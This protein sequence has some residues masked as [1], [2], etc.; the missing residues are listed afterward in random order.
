MPGG[1]LESGRQRRDA[2]VRKREVQLCDA[3]PPP[4]FLKKGRRGAL[5]P[6][7]F[8]ASYHCS[9]CALHKDS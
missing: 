2:H 3:P 9:K 5:Y 1:L 4:S 8:G 6:L 7:L